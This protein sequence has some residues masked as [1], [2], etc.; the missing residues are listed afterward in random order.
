MSSFE[1]WHRLT[2]ERVP[3]VLAGQNNAGCSGLKLFRLEMRLARQLPTT[4]WVDGISFVDRDTPLLLLFLS[5][6]SWKPGT[7]PLTVE[8]PQT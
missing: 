1:Y 4:D 6:S 3:A 7:V 8:M 2:N 5:R